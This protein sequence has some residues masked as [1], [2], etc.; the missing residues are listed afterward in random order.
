MPGK[1]FLPGLALALTHVSW[2]ALLAVRRCAMEA[3]GLHLDS[4]LQ[5]QQIMEAQEHI[6]L[7]GVAGKRLKR[8]AAL[9]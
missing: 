1:H 8:C 5:V 6:L 4:D 7:N 2:M 9:A 3:F